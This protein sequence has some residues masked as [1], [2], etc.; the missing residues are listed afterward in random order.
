MG[1]AESLDA[2]VKQHTP[3]EAEERLI[4]KRVDEVLTAAGGF[5]PIAARHPAGSF[6]KGT[7]LKG[8]KEGDVVA[9]LSEA[10]TDRTLAD[11]ERHLQKMLPEAAV[12]TTYKAI[13]LQFR[14]GVCVDLLPVA[15]SGTTPSGPSVPRKLRHALDGIAH[16]DWARKQIHGSVRHPAVRLMKRLRDI[17]PELRPLSSFA[18]EVAC[19]TC[20][21]RE[22]RG[23]DAALR[24][25]VVGL[26]DLV[27][28]RD[29]LIDPA[30]LHNNLVAD[31]TPTERSAMT[32]KLRQLVASV[33]DPTGASIFTPAPGR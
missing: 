32:V 30:D 10:P 6:A 4:Q 2:I 24:L 15:R 28:S 29:G 3:D 19:V 26:L 17:H 20:V 1:L 27:Q 14:D 18:V 21:P 31:L 33:S 5:T 8:R 9:V 7:M 16:V 22:T 23:L 11:L 25:A 13:R 12:S